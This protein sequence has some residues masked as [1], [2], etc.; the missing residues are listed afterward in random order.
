MASSKNVPLLEEKR[1]F[2]DEWLLNYFVTP[3]HN[4][5]RHYDSRHSEYNTK[6]PAN[7]T[8]RQK[9]VDFLKSQ[10]IRQQTIFSK[11]Q[12]VQKKAYVASLK[13]AWTL[14]KHKKPFSDVDVIKECFSEMTST[15]FSDDKK[16]QDRVRAEF[17]AVSLSRRC[18]TRRAD[19]I[20]LDIEA[21][22]K[23]DIAS[24]QFYSL[25]H[26]LMNLATLPILHSYQ[27]SSY[28]TFFVALAHWPP[29]NCGPRQKTRA[30]H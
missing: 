20:N 29:K 27:H 5:K 25:L 12:T 24:C 15:L 7:S 23:E 28:G 17:N 13:V 22:L 26:V 9:R 14:C 2:Y 10:L 21:Q 4:V 18:I 19:E 3:K 6:Y 1:L 8:E 30:H 16:M 11:A